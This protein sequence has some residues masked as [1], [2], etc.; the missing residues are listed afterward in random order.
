M[1]LFDQLGK[2]E[3]PANPAQILQQLRSNPVSMLKQAGYSIPDGMNN[4]QQ[5]VSYLLQSGQIPQARYQ[6]TM[7]MLSRIGRR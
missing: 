4:P 3:Q 1:G 7:Q 6:Q 5:M 2:K